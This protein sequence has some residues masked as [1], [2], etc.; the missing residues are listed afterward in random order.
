MT[1]TH[2][3]N[4]ITMVENAHYTV[5]VDTQGRLVHLARKGSG[6]G[7][8]IKGDAVSLLRTV[9][10][11]GDNWELPSCESEQR[12]AVQKE[13]S[14]LII[15][16]SKLSCLDCEQAITIRLVVQLDGKYL[17]FSGSLT[18]ESDCMVTDVYFPC[19]GSVQSLA[20]GKP[21]LLWPDCTGQYFDAIAEHL[22]KQDENGG[23]QVL[24]ASYPGPLSMQWMSLVDGKE[25][26]YYAGHDELFHTSALRVV[27]VEAQQVELSIWKSTKWP[28]SNQ[29]RLGTF[30]PVC[31]RSMR[32][33]WRWGLRVCCLGKD[34]EKTVEKLN[35]IKKM[36]GY[37]LVICKQQYG[38]ELWPYTSI[39]DL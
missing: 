8:I 33:P 26:L 13:G 11:Q 24:S 15:E 25:V 7:N 22:G 37:F 12:Y 34:M 21:A 35:W 20:G 38:D 18:N 31:S 39:T 3:E 10:K 2:T 9:L 6:Y 23:T 1:E 14:R 32:G 4:Q 17:R 29:V 36:H 27:S 28:S 5:G 16:A 19:V 30:P